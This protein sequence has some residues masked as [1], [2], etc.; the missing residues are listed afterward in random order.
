[1]K[2]RKQKQGSHYCISVDACGNGIKVKV[3]EALEQEREN[4]AKEIMKEFG[5]QIE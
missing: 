4:L 2:I 3:R 5:D 1:M